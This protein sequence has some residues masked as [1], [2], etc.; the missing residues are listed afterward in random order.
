ML[1][2]QTAAHISTYHAWK[3]HGPEKWN[4]LLCI[5]WPLGSVS[6]IWPP[7]GRQVDLYL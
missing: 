3:R 7:N 1:S 4:D 5:T 6:S 2:R